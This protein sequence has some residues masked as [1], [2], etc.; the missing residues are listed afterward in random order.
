[1]FLDHTGGFRK[2]HGFSGISHFSRFRTIF[3]HWEHD[4]SNQR[5]KL[6]RMMYNLLVFQIKYFFTK[7]QGKG[8]PQG[9]FIKNFFFQ[10]HF[11]FISNWFPTSRNWYSCGKRRFL[12]EMSH[13]HMLYRNC[14][15][16]GG[17]TNY[18]VIKFNNWTNFNFGIW[19]HGE[20]IEG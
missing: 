7:N 19:N 8:P 6:H 3:I 16:C 2:N 13:V 9:F 15:L 17:V 5:T 12:H 11:I 10:I 1:M 18:F 4:I 20:I 14:P